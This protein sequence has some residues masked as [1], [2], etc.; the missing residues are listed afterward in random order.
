MAAN[1]EPT[2]LSSLGV[3]LVKQNVE[4]SSS[5]SKY[6]SCK[7]AKI[8]AP[9]RISVA[10]A[11]RRSRNGVVLAGRPGCVRARR[12]HNLLKSAEKLVLLV[13]KTTALSSRIP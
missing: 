6:L 7:I 1:K 3:R 4:G 5:A 12:V 9:G 11:H 2:T 10:R 13:P 8:T